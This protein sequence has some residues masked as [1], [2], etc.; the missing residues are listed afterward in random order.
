MIDSW[1]VAGGLPWLSSASALDRINCDAV[2][3]A[4]NVAVMAA[5]TVVSDSDDCVRGRWLAVVGEAISAVFAGETAEFDAYTAVIASISVE[6]S[7]VERPAV[8]KR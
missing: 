5:F 6:P 2:A 3:D 8:S 4:A 1:G 7:V